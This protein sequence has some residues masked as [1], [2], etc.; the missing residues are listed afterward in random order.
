M[1]IPVVFLGRRDDPR[2]SVLEDLG[3]T[4]WPWDANPAEV[5]WTPQVLDIEDHQARLRALVQQM[6]RQRVGEGK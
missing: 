1:G 4:I 3:V 5:D 6:I 2:F